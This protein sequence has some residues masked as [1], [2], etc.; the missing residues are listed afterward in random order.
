MSEMAENF[1]AL[2]EI[3]KAARASNRSNSAK[4]LADRGIEFESKNDGAHLIVTGANGAVDF[5]PGTGK[6][7]A[8]GINKSGRGVFNLIRHLEAQDATP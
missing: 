5:W 2:K 4:I 8:R 1:A 7:I 3:S 6:F